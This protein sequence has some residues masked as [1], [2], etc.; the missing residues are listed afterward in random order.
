M[1]L[2]RRKRIFYEGIYS[3]G[4]FPDG[5]IKLDVHF[6]SEDGYYFIWTP[7]WRAVIDLAASAKFL[8]ETNKPRSEWTAELEESYKKL[9]EKSE[10][11]KRIIEVA[12]L[13][14]A[15]LHP[16]YG[17][18]RIDCLFPEIPSDLK[19][20]SEQIF[21]VLSN[22]KNLDDFIVRLSPIVNV[23]KKHFRDEIVKQNFN[24]ILKKFG[25]KL[26][27]RFNIVK[28]KE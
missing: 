17:D 23:H 16:L 21:Y 11:S 14:S 24:K 13:I 12:R 26:D 3:R 15:T 20:K 2:K 25:L 7:P 22:A 19:R 28:D 9:Q 8:E 10:L 18:V 6:R 27:S 5:R 4:T 1:P